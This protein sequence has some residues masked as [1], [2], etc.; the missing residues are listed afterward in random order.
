L[1]ATKAMTHK[2]RVISVFF[3]FGFYQWFS[4]DKTK[5]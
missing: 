5:K 1:A 2:A 4:I 3:I